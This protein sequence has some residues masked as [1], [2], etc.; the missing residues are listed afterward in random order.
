M[1]SSSTEHRDPHPSRGRPAPPS[2]SIKARAFPR[3]SL[4][5][6]FQPYAR[7]H[8]EVPG[9]GLGLFPSRGIIEAHGGQISA[10]SATGE[11]TTVTFWVP[12][13]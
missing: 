8:Q 2:P 12:V 4:P 13:R 10:T 7:A 9:V 3:R 11:G 1:P 6:L 5:R